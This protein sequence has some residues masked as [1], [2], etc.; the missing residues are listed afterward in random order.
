MTITELT[1]GLGPVIATTLFDLAPLGYTQAEFAIAGTAS[2]YERHH[3]DVRVIEQADYQT[4]LVVY[5]P[6][7]PARFNGTVWVEWCNV[8]GGLDAGPD[9][10]FTHT[11]LMRAGA[12]WIGV[13]CQQLGVHGGDGLVLAGDGGLRAASPERYG[14]LHHPGDRFSYDIFSQAGAAVRRE[15]ATLLPGVTVERVLGIGE[16][17]SA[18]RLTTYVNDIDVEAQVFDGFFVHA[19]GGP[20]APLDDDSP[21]LSFDRPPVPFRGDLRVPVMCVEAET[22]L[23]VLGYLPARQPDDDRLVT[24]EI[25]GTSHADVYTFGA[26]MIDTGALPIDELAAAWTPSDELFGTKLQAP[27]N[28]GPQHYVLNAAVAH[29]DGWVRDGTRPPDGGDRL[30]I[31]IGKDKV[32][33]QPDDRGNALGGVR[34]P[35]VD[36]PVAVL[37]G[38]GNTGGPLA[39][40]CGRTVAFAPKRLRRLYRDHDDYV[41]RFAASNAEAVARGHLLATDEG[42]INAL[43]AALSPLR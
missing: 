8:S 17:Q 20:D 10:T 19:R 30:A 31:R 36:V 42:E 40:L 9:W 3:A 28:A 23:V 1:A 26:G 29:L 4:R 33:F 15:A 43:A 32:D 38:L 22:D 5:R 12:A 24:W 6:T 18:F 41:G 25:A 39:H 14:T 34:T 35:H 11:E 16:S 7:D 13:S 2:A 21:A 37:S 27:V